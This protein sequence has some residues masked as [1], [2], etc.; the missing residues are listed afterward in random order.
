MIHSKMGLRFEYRVP[1]IK[2]AQRYFKTCSLF[3][4]IREMKI[5]TTFKI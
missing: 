3:L 1:K 4:K 2:K 5:K